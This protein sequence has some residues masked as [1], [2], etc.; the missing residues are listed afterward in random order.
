MLSASPMPLA[1]SRVIECVESR[2]GP[3]AAVTR[4]TAEATK[5][6]RRGRSIVNKDVEHATEVRCARDSHWKPS[7]ATTR[8]IVQNEAVRP[9]G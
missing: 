3:R 4:I 8:S 6:E 5:V 1:K 7:A 9:I 2:F